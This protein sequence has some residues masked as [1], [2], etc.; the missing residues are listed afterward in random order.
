MD[1]IKI[2]YE[3]FNNPFFI[4]IGVISVCSENKLISVISFLFLLFLYLAAFWAAVAE[5]A[6]F[7]AIV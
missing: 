1:K 5:L 7:F 6:A 2:V 4:I 3:F